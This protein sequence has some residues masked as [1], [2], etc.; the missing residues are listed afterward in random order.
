MSVSFALK[1]M[2]LEFRL[3]SGRI[4][5]LR[6][7][8]DKKRRNLTRLIEC[9]QMPST[10]LIGFTVFVAI[11]VLIDMYQRS[12]E[13]SRQISLHPDLVRQTRLISAGCPSLSAA[14][15]DRMG[16]DDEPHW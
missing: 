16:A 1:R 7:S 3:S 10:C 13:R 9:G 4:P 14:F 8:N 15:A 11:V 5:I 12:C 6:R 2:R